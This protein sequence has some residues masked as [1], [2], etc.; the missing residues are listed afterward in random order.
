MTP[1]N[2]FVTVQLT[3]EMLASRADSLPGYLSRVQ[4][5]KMRITGQLL[6]LS[7]SPAGEDREA[8]IWQWQNTCVELLETLQRFRSSI[9]APGDID[10]FY[11]SLEEMLHAVLVALEQH[12]GEHLLPDLTVPHSYAMQAKRQ[13]HA[14]LQSAERELKRNGLAPDLLEIILSTVKQF[15]DDADARIDFRELSYYR[16]LLSRLLITASFEPVPEEQ[17]NLQIHFLLIHLNFNAAEYFLYGTDLMRQWLRVF[18]DMHECVNALTLCIREVRNIPLL[19]EGSVYL[20][21]GSP[22][23]HQLAAWLEEERIFLRMLIET[24]QKPARYF[25]EEN[26]RFCFAFLRAA[27]NT[28]RLW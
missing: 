14:R 11:A 17:F 1:F 18:G 22:V 23:K 9:P 6:E 2:H 15:T 24:G 10:T 26:V 12:F 16:E 13:L 27:I 5:E 7:S 21:K 3:P 20:V 4:E 28:G 8:L 25:E 19:R